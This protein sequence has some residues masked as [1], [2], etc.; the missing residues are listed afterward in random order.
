MCGICGA[1]GRDAARVTQRM[2]DALRHRGPDDEGIHEDT[3]RGIA[4]GARRLSIIDLDGGHQPLSNE[5]GTV[6]AA[7]NGEVYNYAALRDDLARRGH[8]FASRTD[9]EV[10][11]HLYEEF[12]SDLVHALEG[13]YAFAIWDAPRSQLLLARDRFGEK[14]LFY[15]ATDGELSFSS[16]LSSLRRG[17][18]NGAVDPEAIDAVLRLGYVVGPASALTGVAQLAAGHVLRWSPSDRTPRISRYWNIPSPAEGTAAVD[19]LEALTDET[20]DLLDRAVRSRLIADVPVGVLLSGGLDSTLIAALARP[21][22]ATLKTFTVAYEHGAVNEDEPARATARLLAADHHELR[23]T[24]D[25]V[26]THVPAMLGAIDQPIADPAYIPLA[27]VSRLAREHVTVAVGG[28]GADELFFGYPRYRWLDRA[29]RMQA[30]VPGIA[31]AGMA[32]AVRATGIGGRVRRLA[33]VLQPQAP[34]DRHLRWVTDG[35]MG[36]RAELYGP[37]LEEHVDGRALRDALAAMWPQ[38]P[39]AARTASLF[40]QRLYLCDDI[41]QKADRAS[42]AASLELRT[43]F[44]ERTLAEFSATVDPG[45]HL[46]DNG[47]QLLRRVLRRRLPDAGGGRPKM[48]FRVPLADW[49][50]GPLAPAAQDHLLEG[51]LVR[52]GWVDRTATAALLGRL[53]DGDAA[54]ADLWPLL[55][56]G[57]WLDST[58]G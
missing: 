51:A 11:V 25:W 27:A 50:R 12:G 36:D 58:R 10:L 48:A 21:H 45:T 24:A 3:S 6:W 57:A 22:I 15:A 31:G 35:R 26:A 7:L 37:A 19:S 38:H 32:G 18:A 28:E 20:E 40:D 9:T 55:C 41:L 2:N 56:V 23:L 29:A 16:E 52:D 49:L 34:L 14:P 53:D 54:A 47:K 46:A 42:M 17:T 33:G 30:V 4:I 8:V 13:M 5:D 43:P 44:L 1:T 39:S